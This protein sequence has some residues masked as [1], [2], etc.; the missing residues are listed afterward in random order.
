[1]NIKIKKYSFVFAILFCFLLCCGK[2]EGTQITPKGNSP[3]MITSL[4]LL[5]EKPTQENDLMV[6][7]QSR[8]P[9][10]DSVTY[11]Y[12]WI[13][14]DKEMIGEEGNTLKSGKFKK[15]DL[16]RVLVTP[17]DGK[18]EGKS[19]SSEEIKI[20]NSPPV[21]QEVWLEPKIA[22]LREPLKAYVKSFDPDGDFIYFTYKWEKNG[23]PIEE[24][25]GEILEKEYFKKG[26]QIAV[27]VTPDDKE[28]F[29]KPKRSEPVTISNSP[30]LIISSP[31]S[32]IDGTKYLY[33]VKATD[34]DNDPIT[35]T[36]K[37]GPKGM[38]IDK[39]TGLIQWNIRKEDQGNHFIEI[40][41]S[42]NEG[43][44]S[45]QNYTLIVEFK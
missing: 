30:P 21:I 44:K 4:T 45:L 10:N 12:Q 31:P 29:G 39:K 5:P 8:D 35:F 37:K 22:T 25:R 7:V 18:V 38:E 3:P 23:V 40:E 13:K 1:M 36:L 43:A 34:P 15:G 41:A 6:N 11:R 2:K 42:D 9:D 17:Y 14:N 19:V 28:S 32:S 33:Q 20:L 24:V 27:V 26:D 16:I